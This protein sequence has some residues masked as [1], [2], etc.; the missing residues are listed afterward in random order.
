MED[1]KISPNWT[2]RNYCKNGAFRF[3]L[4]KRAP[5]ICHN[6]LTR[7]GGG[8]VRGGAVGRNLA[9]SIP[10]VVIGIFH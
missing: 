7:V 9:G 10:D 4:K 1:L 8:E 6:I 5:G 3:I 2:G